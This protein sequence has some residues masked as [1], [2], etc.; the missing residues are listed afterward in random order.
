MFEKLDG[1]DY[2]YAYK[3]GEVRFPGS[4]RYARYPKEEDRKLGLIAL[5]DVLSCIGSGCDGPQP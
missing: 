4:L 2:V 1:E 3:G 5:N